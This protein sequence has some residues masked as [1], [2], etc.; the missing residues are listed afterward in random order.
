LLK[1]G[2]DHVYLARL[3]L[4]AIAVPGAATRPAVLGSLSPRCQ[5]TSFNAA[6]I[7]APASSPISAAK[8]P[9]ADNPCLSDSQAGRV[10]AEGAARRLGDS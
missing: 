2:T 1:T 4:S 6:T 8:I 10:G 9:L 5:S 3:R 7:A